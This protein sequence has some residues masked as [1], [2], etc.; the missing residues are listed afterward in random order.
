MSSAVWNF[1]GKVAL[2]AGGATG[3]GEATVRKFAAARAA[4]VFFDLNEA[5][6]EALARELQASGANVR[7]LPGD[8]TDESQV[9]A[10]VADVVAANGQL[11][12]AINNVGGIAKN[13]GDRSNIRLADTSLEAWQATVDLNLTSCF[14]GMKYQIPV[15]V[16]AG[17]GAIVNLTSLAGMNFSNGA[18]PAYAASKAGVIHLTRYAAIMHAKEK[19]RVNVV[20]P[21]L[22]ATQAMLANMPDE[23]TREARA[24][25]LPMKRMIAP[26]EIADACLWACSDAATGVTGMTIPVDGGTA[27]L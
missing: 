25:H 24:A 26:S 2:V 20:A 9:K 21:G 14:L 5:L 17:G 8:A 6:G 11:D 3:I 23:Q 4:V 12:M 27:A 22:T 18:S 1:A 15:M 10:I 7:F 13:A 16:A 19:V